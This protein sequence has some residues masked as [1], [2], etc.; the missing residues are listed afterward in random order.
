MGQLVELHASNIAVKF[1]IVGIKSLIII[2][3]LDL[4]C[5]F[6]KFISISLLMEPYKFLLKII[7]Q[8]TY[9]MNCKFLNQVCV[10]RS[11][12]ANWFL[13]I[14]FMRLY[15]CVCMPPRP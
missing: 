9:F 6:I 4:A 2:T 13:E 5:Q 8:H 7:M 3:D 15:V 12:R 11:W 14:T 10:A 1:A